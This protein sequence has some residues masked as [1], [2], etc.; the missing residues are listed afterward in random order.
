[1]P[2]QK[3]ITIHFPGNHDGSLTHQVCDFGEDLW[4]EIEPTKLGD[5]GGIEKIDLATDT[6]CIQ[7]H[8]T[9]KIGT[10]RK[11]VDQLLKTHLLEDKSEVSYS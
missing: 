10:V 3:T 11:L 7:I 2:S 6:L 9:R 1:M 8:H 5:V 4:R